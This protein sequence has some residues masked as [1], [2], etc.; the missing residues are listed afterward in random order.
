MCCHNL[1]R[2]RRFGRVNPNWP[3]RSPG[4]GPFETVTLRRDPE[5]IAFT[6]P[7]NATGLFDLEPE[8]NLLLPFEGMGVDTIWRLE[9]PK[10][11]N[12]ID[13][14]SIADVLLTCGCRKPCHP[15]R[16]G[17][18][19]GSDRRADPAGEPARWCP[20]QVDA[21]AR[22]A[23]FAAVT[24]VAG[25]SCSGRRTRR[26]LAAGAVRRSSAS[27]PGTRGGRWP[28]SAPRSRSRAAP[29]RAS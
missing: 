15:M 20:E 29:G 19:R 22:Q 21:D 23:G 13:Y 26:G 10:P 18:I 7:V 6:A 24:G 28:S 12:P 16:P 1:A 27:G 14:Q 17:Y 8:G 11:A 5:S 3:H 25:E 2:R 9:L 4:G